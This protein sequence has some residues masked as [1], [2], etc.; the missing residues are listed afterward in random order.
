MGKMGPVPS[1]YRP[2]WPHVALL[3]THLGQP[4]HPPRVLPGTIWADNAVTRQVLTGPRIHVGNFTKQQINE[5][6]KTDSGN[7]KQKTVIRHHQFLIPVV[8]AI[9]LGACGNDDQERL[10]GSLD[11]HATS[12]ELVLTEDGRP[13]PAVLA[14]EQVLHRDNGEEPTTLDPHLAEGVS[15]A[16]I[17]RDLFEGLTAES[18]QGRVIPGAAI[19]WNISRDGKTYTF[20][21]RREA[22]WSNGDPVTAEDFVYGLRRSASPATA[23]NYAQ[24]LLPIANAA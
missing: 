4:N 10:P 22:R 3:V 18:P 13:D 12:V 17:L 24:V 9:L 11:R 5:N 23:S 15:A 20:Y 21:L 6:E 2:K 14:L 7:G 16:H 8:C 1:G 19:R